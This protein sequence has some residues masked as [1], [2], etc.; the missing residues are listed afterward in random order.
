MF[1]PKSL[2]GEMLRR[3]TAIPAT[4]NMSDILRKWDLLNPSIIQ[5]QFIAW[6]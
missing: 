3:F 1:S 2:D 6:K 5:N 4:K